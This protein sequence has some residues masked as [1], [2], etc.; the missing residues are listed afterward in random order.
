VAA[1]IGKDAYRL[2]MRAFVFSSFFIG[3]AGAFYVWYLTILDP[4]AFSVNITFTI[5]IA[6]I[7]G[8]MGSNSGVV[9]G[10]VVLLGLR[11]AVTY[12]KVGGVAPETL[13]SLQDAT[14]GLILVLIL[15]FWRRGLLPRR[16]RKY[17]RPEPAAV[18]VEGRR[19]P[20]AEPS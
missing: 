17:R 3:I 5:W 13:T 10:V 11:E 20:I 4:G 12:L 2:S 7:I 16:A 18:V 15:L 14:Q 6:A 8:G 1:S 9:L 19:E